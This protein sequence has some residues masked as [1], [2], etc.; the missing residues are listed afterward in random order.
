MFLSYPFG[1]KGYKVY[2]LATKTCFVSRDVGFKKNIFPF[3]HWLANSMSVPISSC[4]T[5]FS[6]QPIIPDSSSSSFPTTEFT[7]FSKDLAVL[8]LMSSLTLF[9]LILTIL[10][11]LVMFLIPNLMIN[12][13]GSPLELG[14]LPVIFRTII[15]TWLLHMCLPQFHFLN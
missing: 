8:L 14:N 12:L 3:K 7:P 4:P 13:L 2:D 6:S 10:I 15:A 1:T 11:L 5:M 9:I